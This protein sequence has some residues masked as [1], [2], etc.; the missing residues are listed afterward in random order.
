MSSQREN[1]QPMVTT[2]VWETEKH[3]CGTTP[4]VVDEQD[5]V[6]SGAQPCLC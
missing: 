6:G 2:V 5:L 1:Y 3:F 4:K